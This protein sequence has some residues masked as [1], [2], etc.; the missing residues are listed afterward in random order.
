MAC[1][2]S[3]TKSSVRESVPSLFC[4]DINTPKKRESTTLK[5]YLNFILSRY[6]SSRKVACW[7]RPVMARAGK[8]L[9]N[10]LKFHIHVFIV[11][12]IDRLNGPLNVLDS[13]KICIPDT[14]SVWLAGWRRPHSGLT[15]FC[16]E[17]CPFQLR[18]FS[19]V[20]SQMGIVFMKN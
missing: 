19:R 10:S 6:V 11:S 14:G 16:A 12:G 13:R 15:M 8:Y 5:H 1:D 20:L 18:V 9:P 7:C 2:D 4:N 17:F 3:V